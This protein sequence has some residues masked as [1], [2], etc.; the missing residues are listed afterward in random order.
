MNSAC[1]LFIKDY[2]CFFRLHKLTLDY[3][4]FDDMV[5]YYTRFGGRKIVIESAGQAGSQLVKE[6]ILIGENSQ[7][8]P[9]ENQ[10]I[11]I[12]TNDWI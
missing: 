1:T 5:Q 11:Q 9:S 2:L 7:T 8:F 6:G 12:R 10:L 4:I 3:L